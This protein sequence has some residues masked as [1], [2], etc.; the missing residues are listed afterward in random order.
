[1]KKTIMGLIAFSAVLTLTACSHKSTESADTFNQSTTQTIETENIKGKKD[2]ENNALEWLDVPYAQAERWQAPKEV[3]K[4]D[5]TFDA[6]EY[7]E[8]IFNFLITK[9]SALKMN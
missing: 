2:T 6:T 8:K 7:G 3:D 9:S 1:M 5:D 4:W